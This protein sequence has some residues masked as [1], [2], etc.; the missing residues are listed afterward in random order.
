MQQIGDVRQRKENQ[1]KADH[2]QQQHQRVEEKLSRRYGAEHQVNGKE[3]HGKKLNGNEGQQHPTPQLFVR[4]ASVHT[5]ATVLEEDK[6]QLEEVERRQRQLERL[7]V[8]EVSL[9]EGLPLLGM[10]IG[11]RDRPENGVQQTVNLGSVVVVEEAAHQA[12][13]TADVGQL[14]KDEDTVHD[15]GQ[16]EENEGGV[17]G[18]VVRHHGEANEAEVV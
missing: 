2:V 13:Q 10:S 7:K 9:N 6:L 12:V 5:E 3:D 17:T 11:R 16:V 14:Q 4:P 15:G 18:R 8:L 1:H